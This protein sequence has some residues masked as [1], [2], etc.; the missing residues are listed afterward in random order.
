MKDLRTTLRIL[1]LAAL[2]CMWSSY[3]MAYK[4]FDG[5]FVISAP[6]WDDNAILVVNNSFTVESILNDGKILII[7]NDATVTVSTYFANAGVIYVFGTLDISKSTEPYTGSIY[8]MK[9]G[10]FIGDITRPDEIHFDCTLSD[11]LTSQMAKG[12]APSEGEDGWKDFYVK[13]AIIRDGDYYPF[14]GITSYYTDETEKNPI[15]DLEAWKTGEGKI[16]FISL[17]KNKAIEEINDARQGLLYIESFSNNV[18][19]YITCIM[20]AETIDDVNSA[21]NVALDIIKEWKFRS[22]AINEINDAMKEVIVY[23]PDCEKKVEVYIQSIK[24]AETHDLANNAKESALA[25]IEKIMKIS[26]SIITNYLGSLAKKQGGPVIEVRGNDGRTIK[27]YNIK[28]V[29]FSKEE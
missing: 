5:E 6:E 13:D 27:L 26:N 8:A 14:P 20:N 3:A 24:D 18:D 21:K 19:N 1:C 17:M 2:L 4:V 11:I 7:N 28:N 10:Q 25:M 22:D 15:P 12:K 16:P 9:G 29:K 23:Y